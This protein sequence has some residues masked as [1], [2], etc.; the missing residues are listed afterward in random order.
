MRLVFSLFVLCALSACTQPFVMIPGGALKG[1]STAAPAN[2]PKVPDVIQLE[3]QPSDP[4]SIN[5]WAV[6]ESGHLYVGTEEAKWV[7]MIEASDLVK[8]KV[9]D[10]LYD[11][12][13]ELVT[14]DGVR[15]RV[16]RVYGTKYDFSLDDDLGDNVKLYRLVARH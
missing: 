13:A 14:D 10:K 2:W 7:P 11:L 3:V 9:E 4:Y 8:V 1:E 12:R 15:T 6:T 16:G 5:I